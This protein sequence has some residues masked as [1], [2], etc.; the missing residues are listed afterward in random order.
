MTILWEGSGYIDIKGVAISV[1]VVSVLTD[2]LCERIY[3][4]VSFKGTVR[5]Q[6]N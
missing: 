1:I 6:R 5:L 2:P 4:E 3:I